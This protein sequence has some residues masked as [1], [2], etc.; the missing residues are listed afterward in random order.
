V[1]DR[2]LRDGPVPLLVDDVRVLRCRR[3]WIW[4][5]AV[6][7]L[8]AAIA[9][10][11]LVIDDRA[12]GSDVDAPACLFVG[13]LL[14]I[15]VAVVAWGTRWRGTVRLD[16]SALHVVDDGLETTLPWRELGDVRVH[17][18]FLRSA[19]VLERQGSEPVTLPAANLG[20]APHRARNLIDGWRCAVL[21]RPYTRH[22][23]PVWEGVRTPRALVLG[24]LAVAAVA[25]AAAPL[26]VL[27]LATVA[28][29]ALVCAYVTTVPVALRALP[30]QFTRAGEHDDLLGTVRAPARLVLASMLA[31]ALYFLAGIALIN[32]TANIVPVRHRDLDDGQAERVLEDHSQIEVDL[33]CPPARNRTLVCTGRSNGVR[34]RVTAPR[35]TDPRCNTPDFDALAECELWDWDRATVRG[36]R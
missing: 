20:M 16:A 1:K 29:A 26:G 23:A 4:P 24:A 12:F 6:V 33:D 34:Y 31:A 8:P 27:G 21:G 32:T 3:L 14:G 5:L 11:L 15:A 25:A 2:R 7:S 18:A 36:S 10:L 13:G 17:H 35:G 9:G 30:T 22:P 28:G 19:V